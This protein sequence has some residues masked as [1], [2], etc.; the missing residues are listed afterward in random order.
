MEKENKYRVI[1][2]FNKTLHVSNTTWPPRIHRK[3]QNQCFIV[4]RGLTEE[5]A[6]DLAD[7]LNNEHKKQREPWEGANMIYSYEIDSFV[8]LHKS[9]F[10]DQ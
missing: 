5:E 3:L 8:Y 2:R 10:L 1:Y 4:D 7:R 9:Y 6:Q